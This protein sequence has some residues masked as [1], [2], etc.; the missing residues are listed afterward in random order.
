MKKNYYVRTGSP[1]KKTKTQVLREIANDERRKAFTSQKEQEEQDKREADN[2]HAFNGSKKRIYEAERLEILATLPPKFQVQRKLNLM[3]ITKRKE[4]EDRLYEE[5]KTSFKID[6]K[7]DLEEIYSLKK[8]EKDYHNDPYYMSAENNRKNLLQSTEEYISRKKKLVEDGEK[9]IQISQII[10]NS[11]ARSRYLE[12]ASKK[13]VPSRDETSY[14]P[15]KRSRNKNIKSRYMEPTVSKKS[16]E[17]TPSKSPIKKFKRPKKKVVEK[18]K[19]T[20]VRKPSVKPVK[21]SVP[22]KEVVKP[23]RQSLKPKSKTPNKPQETT[24]RESLTSQKE[25][26]K[27]NEVRKKKAEPPKKPKMSRIKEEPKK[28]VDKKVE[29]EIDIDLKAP[30]TK[31]AANLIQGR[32]LARKKRREEEEEKN[33]MQQD[34]KE[35]EIDIDLKAP[36]TKKAANLIQGRFLARKKRREEEAA[37]EEADK[38]KKEEEEE[39][40]IDLNAE[41]TKKAANLIQGRFLARKKRREEEEE[42]ANQLKASTQTKKEE[43][44]KPE[45]EP[46]DTPIEP[47]ATVEITLSNNNFPPPVDN[48]V[49]IQIREPVNLHLPLEEITDFIPYSRSNFYKFVN[50]FSQSRNPRG[51]SGS[52]NSLQNSQKS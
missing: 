35:E 43:E 39:I 25:A 50:T 51:S 37:K 33:K 20:I 14:S 26:E 30:E 2:W 9:K 38:T 28:K 5:S 17:K 44:K 19:E 6:S 40:D 4:E 27:K 13:R 15:V 7:I 47:Q 32:F 52:Y 34:Q 12:P 1:S 24:K 41:D 49:S 31:K 22:K 11:T 8:F 36:E 10:S 48:P 42:K 16:K 21:K 18:P 29:E 23:V 3:D 46:A 45:F